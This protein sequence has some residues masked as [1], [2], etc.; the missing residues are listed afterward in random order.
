MDLSQR[1]LWRGDD[2]VPI[3]PKAFETL[4]ALVEG[5]G[6]VISKGELLDRVWADSYVEEATLAKNISTLRQTL[7]RFVKDRDLIETIPRRGYRFVGDVEK[8]DTV[9]E[10]ILIERR[11]VTRIV[12]GERA[13]TDPSKDV[14]ARKGPSLSKTVATAGAVI[15]LIAAAI[16]LDYVFSPRES[17]FQTAF[18]EIRTEKLLEGS[19]I[20]GV[21]ISPDGRYVSLVRR[22]DE[23]DRIR[24]RL[25]SE[26]NT[27]EV[28]R[29]FG[30]RIIGTTFSGDASRLY[31]S[32]YKKG[33]PVPAKG[34]L[35]SVPVLGGAPLEILKDIDSPAAVSRDGRRLAFVRDDPEAKIS[36]LIIADGK[37]GNEEVLA[38]RPLSSGFAR[39]G[40]AFSPD[41]KKLSVG[42]ADPATRNAQVAV[43][44]VATGKLETLTKARWIWI[45]RSVWL[46]DGSGV[47]FVAYGA[48]TPN[49]TDEIWLVSYPEGNSRVLTNGINGLN[50]LSLQADSRVIAADRLHRVVTRYSGEFETGRIGVIA[51]TVREESLLP[52]GS[53]R[54][55]SGEIVFSQTRNGNADIWMM[56]PDGRK[57]VQLTSDPAA[58]FAPVYS[59]DGKR[60]VFIS[61]REGTMDLWRM[62]ADGTGAVRL[63]GP[64]GTSRPSVAVNADGDEFVYYS[65]PG[66]DGYNILFRLTL[67]GGTPERQNDF[68]VYRPQVSPDGAFVA[69]LCGDPESKSGGVQSSLELRVLPL[70]EE[71]GAA[72]RFAGAGFDR[73]TV[74]RW[75]REEDGFVLIASKRV[76]DGSAIVRI[77]PGKD[78]IDE[79]RRWDSGKVFDL[80]FSPDGSKIY[81]ERGEEANSIIRIIDREAR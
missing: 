73:S 17:R 59:R 10:E 32:A 76:G 15:V 12:A 64:V 35:Y 75:R 23:G 24:L 16:G 68:P 25:M 62:N 60:I 4:L 8:T 58:D 72:G 43:V 1:C 66:G 52:L 33:D 70:G 74:F 47:V 31:F 54:N 40:P 14:R 81:L 48:G 53:G 51:M 61:N 27:V 38:E 29:P 46:K 50:G 13:D 20:G 39:G 21:Q 78:V 9:E 18:R 63:A 30:L 49:L 65:A 80:S 36:R 57:S 44:D 34:V 7:G 37:G 55:A 26:G 11:S 2:L 6:N 5:K 67:A 69:C 28:L 22:G 19:R 56:E 3:T 77:R 71:T 42:I 79:I 45:G 41:G